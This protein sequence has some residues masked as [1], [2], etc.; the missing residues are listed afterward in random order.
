MIEAGIVGDG[1]DRSVEM[2]LAMKLMWPSSKD[3][4]EST[5]RAAQELSVLLKAQRCTGIIE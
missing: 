2:N 4:S 3:V 1:I 5:R